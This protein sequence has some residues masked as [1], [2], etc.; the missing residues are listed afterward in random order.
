MLGLN[1]LTKDGFDFK[2]RSAVHTPGEIPTRSG[3]GSCA[4]LACLIPVGVSAQIQA[5][6]LLNRV[7]RL[8]RELTAL[9][10]HVYRVK[11]RR[12]PVNRLPLC[13]PTLYGGSAFGAY[14]AA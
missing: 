7:D 3:Y 10:R 6:E 1:N 11:L 14:H 8:Q 5:Y 4:V 12:L 13:L 2:G 9:Q